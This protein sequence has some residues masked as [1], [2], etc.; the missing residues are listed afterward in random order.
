MSFFT[1]L[2]TTAKPIAVDKPTI[3][4]TAASTKGESTTIP[5]TGHNYKER[6]EREPSC[7][8]E[9]IRVRY[10]SD[11]EFREENTIAKTNH[12]LKDEVQS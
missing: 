6:T 11:C 7:S 1:L 10:C 8:L 3:V 12:S 5:K 9:G 4:L 2:S